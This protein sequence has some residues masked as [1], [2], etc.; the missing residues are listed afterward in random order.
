MYE[1]F[2]IFFKNSKLKGRKIFLWQ[3]C[4]KN[5]NCPFKTWHFPAFWH[6]IN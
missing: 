4:T 6:T 2:Y 5:H 1:Q 3:T